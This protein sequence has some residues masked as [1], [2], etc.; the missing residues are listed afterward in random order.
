MAMHS[1]SRFQPLLSLAI[2]SEAWL[3]ADS[4]SEAVNIQ[5][6]FTTKSRYP[7]ELRGREFSTARHVAVCLVDGSTRYLVQATRVK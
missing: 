3:A 5:R 1:K 4:A 2:G 6:Q 7:A